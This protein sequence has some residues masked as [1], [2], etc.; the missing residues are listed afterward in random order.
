MRILFL[1]IVG[2]WGCVT[3]E[4]SRS[5]LLAQILRP[6][7]GYEGLTHKMCVKKDILG[8]CKAYEITGYP[9]TK[10]FVDEL[11]SLHF[12]CKAGKK[13]T[14]PCFQKSFG[15][16]H[17]YS[18]GWAFWKKETVEFTDFKSNYDKLINS[19]LV[20]F[21]QDKFHFEDM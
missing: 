14:K 3:E 5:P 18:T 1:I 20:C 9:A 2:L 19:T 13:R 21:S 8:S 10:D 4:L 12:V 11:N 6:R 16:C 17:H 7:P 15:I